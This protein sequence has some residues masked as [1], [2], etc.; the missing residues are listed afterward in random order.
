MK[1]SPQFLPPKTPFLLTVVREADQESVHVF[2]VGLETNSTWKAEWI[3][4]LPGIIFSP[5]GLARAGHD[6]IFSLI[7]LGPHWRL[8]AYLIWFTHSGRTSPFFSSHWLLSISSRLQLMMSPQNL[9]QIT[10]LSLWCS[11]KPSKPEIHY[12]SFKPLRQR[13][14]FLSQLYWDI[15]HIS[16][17][18]PFLNVQLNDFLIYSQSS[19]HHHDQ[20]SIFSSPQKGTLCSL[21]VSAH[22]LQA[23]PPLAPPHPHT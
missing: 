5:S 12:P 10:N 18:S 6:S 14:C 16:Y 2:L 9:T 13:C 3:L 19:N 15:I 8:P 23:P 20:F 17:N 4:P 21:A 1:V 11:F 22:F 7:S